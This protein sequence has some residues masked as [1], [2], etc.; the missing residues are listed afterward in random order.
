MKEAIFRKADETKLD[1]QLFLLSQILANHLDIVMAQANL[2]KIRDAFENHKSPQILRLEEH[3]FEALLEMKEALKNKFVTIFDQL[4]S[5][6]KDSSSELTLLASVVQKT[7]LT[8]EIRKL[9]NEALADAS[10]LSL[11]FSDI[12]KAHDDYMIGSESLQKQLSS[13][14]LDLS[15]RKSRIEARFTLLMNNK[16]K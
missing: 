15:T 11:A 14:V 5:D 4:I 12:V 13:K 8:K 2:T 6:L 9:I 16:I 1:Q 7:K 3:T 10:E